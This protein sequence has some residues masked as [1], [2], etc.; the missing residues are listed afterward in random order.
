METKRKR[1]RF[2]PEFKATVV[3]EALSGQSLPAKLCHYHNFTE[4]QLLQWKP[5]RIENAEIFD[6]FNVLA[7]F[8][9]NAIIF[10]REL[11]LGEF[12]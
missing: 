6:P 5:Q 1:R 4:E 9:K 7:I 12:Y 2:T 3:I 10:I 11:L 8:G